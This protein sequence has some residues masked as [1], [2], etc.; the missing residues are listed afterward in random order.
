MNALFAGGIFSRGDNSGIF[1]GE[2]KISFYPLETKKTTFFAKNVIEKR[3]ILNC[4]GSQGP[5]AP[6]PTLMSMSAH[7]TQL[8]VW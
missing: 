4:K 6:F 3:Q 5:S 2:V 1:Q 7:P 8:P